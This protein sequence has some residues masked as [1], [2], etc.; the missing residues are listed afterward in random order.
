MANWQAPY[1]P[2]NLPIVGVR[3]DFVNDCFDELLEF[4]CRLLCFR[5]A[6]PRKCEQIINQAAHSICRIDNHANVMP[7]FLIKRSVG[8]PLQ[9]LGKSGDVSNRRAQVMR[10]GV[11]ERF[12]F[13][14]DSSQLGG[15]FDYPLLQFSVEFVNF[16]FC[17]LA[18]G[19]VTIDFHNGRRSAVLVASQ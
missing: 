8:M 2:H 9:K 1:L 6:D 18:F 7:A 5:A 16:F 11:S 15:A 14:V 19:H 4:N 17:A 12:E 3:R 10:H 13:F